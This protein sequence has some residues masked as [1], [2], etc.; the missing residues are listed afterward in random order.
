MD[1]ITWFR[2]GN[3]L[4]SSL[5]DLG[6]LDEALRLSEIC[7]GVIQKLH[8]AHGS[9]Y[10]YDLSTS[11]HNL[12]NRFIN[13]KRYEEAVEATQAAVNLRAK[14]AK[15]DP[16][17][18]KAAL[19]HSSHNIASAYSG[20]GQHNE[21]LKRIQ[22]AIDIR[23]VLAANDPREFN[24]NLATSYNPREFNANLATSYDD[25]GCF[26]SRAGKDEEGAKSK[27]LAARIWSTLA[28]TNPS[29]YHAKL[30]KSLE[31]ARSNLE[32][33][34]KYEDAIP[35][36]RKI[37]DAWRKMAADNSPSHV[38]SLTISLSNLASTLIS[39]QDYSEALK[40]ITECLDLYRTALNVLSGDTKGKI[41]CQYGKAL[42]VYS[43][44]LE[45]MDRLDEARNAA[46]EGIAVLEKN[47]LDDLI[48]FCPGM[49]EILQ[50]R[51]AKLKA[52]AIPQASTQS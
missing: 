52:V 8:D 20:L 47:S 23:A 38:S 33:L 17:K 42:K 12:G 5:M 28:E 31:I 24:A 9:F 34:R 3:K 32:K 36:A 41:S 16:R 13:K 40:I 46:Q 51:L 1:P 22:V 26:Y 39:A 48:A 29:T 6:F 30:V 44:S 25:Q 35:V 14:L 45:K 4:S 37:V 19:A 15:D 2:R 7:H 18:Y 21:A 11:F 43:V 50:T 10:D 27:Q 49:L